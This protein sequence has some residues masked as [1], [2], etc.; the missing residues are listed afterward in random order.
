M[1]R[2]AQK[3]HLRHP[4]GHLGQCV[5]NAAPNG[6]LGSQNPGFEEPPGHDV[7]RTQEPF[8]HKTCAMA[9]E[10]A[11]S[12]VVRIRTTTSTVQ[13]KPQ[14]IDKTDDPATF[15]DKAAQFNPQ[16]RH[17][18]TLA[19]VRSLWRLGARSVE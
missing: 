17:S 2:M 19:D 3:L 12:M 4:S 7:H 18:S 14:K 5:D 8:A 1:S 6:N 13:V 11:C 10:M 15:A 9:C 16:A